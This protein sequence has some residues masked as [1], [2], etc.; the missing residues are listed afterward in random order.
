MF[1]SWGVF[2]GTTI[3]PTR[4]LKDGREHDARNAFSRDVWRWDEFAWALS[5]LRAAKSVSCRETFL[6]LYA[7]PGDVDWFD[8]DGWREVVNHWRLLARLAK[9]GGL[10]GLAYDAEPYEK[11][12]EQFR[13]AAQSGHERH[14]FAE[15]RAKARERGREVMRAVAEEYPTVTIF[16]FRL[17]SDLVP[18][19]DT[20][21]FTRALEADVYGLQPAFVDGWLDTGPESLR[22]IEGTEEIG[23]H[24]NDR[25]AFLNGYA[26][27]KLRLPDF[28]ASE[29]REKVGRQF[30]IGHSLYLD[31]YL[32]SPGHP[33]HIDSNGTTPAAR[34]AVNL[35]SALE[36]S[37]ALV[38]VYS[39]AGNWWPS[40]NKEYK[41]WPEKFPG[42]I[43]AI[44]QAK[45]PVGFTLEFLARDRTSPNL[46]PN[47]DFSETSLLGGVKSWFTWQADE[48]KG[49]F[50]AFEGR[51]RIS[52][53]KE[54]CYGTLVKANG[55][56]VLAV[57]LKVRSAGRGVASL[58]IG[59][60]TAGGTFLPKQHNVRFLAVAPSGQDGWQTIVGLIVV[61]SGA[62]TLVFMPS[63]A[64]EGPVDYVE[65]D[66]A[67]LKVVQGAS[68]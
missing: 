33:Y 54:A 36:A 5:D 51:I 53:A 39:E 7:N 30:L 48:S 64:M 21:D 58:A 24:A 32:T 4:R 12:K 8:D 25:T 63:V 45:D 20:G 46:L 3:R 55:G 38:W 61:P 11:P 60:K 47:A 65:F 29:H 52:G 68:R 49:T 37:D 34:L 13:Y 28:V 2:D 15:Y 42:V 43:P 6:L 56:D 14:S 17:F 10:R 23:Y 35:R 40:G 67:E 22:V 50:A 18:L 1:E 44:R 31:A 62:T 66:D 41:K 27:L 26:T 57:K 9:Q 16:A 59:W 19:L